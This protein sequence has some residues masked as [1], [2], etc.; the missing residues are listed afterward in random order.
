MSLF[1]NGKPVNWDD[2]FN[3]NLSKGPKNP[4]SL[5]D[6]GN[7]D[8][9]MESKNK[10][11]FTENNS[12]KTVAA[13]SEKPYYGLAHY[14]FGKPPRS[15]EDPDVSSRILENKYIFIKDIFPHL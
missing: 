3:N 6:T 15:I 13:A 9:P 4:D 7:A 1:N 2:P 11:N 8:P 14:L 5:A 12:K 10:R